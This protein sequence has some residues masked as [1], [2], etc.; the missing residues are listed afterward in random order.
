M[1]PETPHGLGLYNFAK[2]TRK[3]FEAFALILKTPPLP[4]FENYPEEPLHFV[5]RFIIREWGAFILVRSDS[6]VCNSRETGCPE[7]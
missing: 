5:D 6:S 3:I 1:L 7:I 2:C 4:D